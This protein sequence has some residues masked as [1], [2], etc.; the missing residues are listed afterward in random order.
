L[1]SKI[2][3]SGFVGFGLTLVISSLRRLRFVHAGSAGFGFFDMGTNVVG[4]DIVGTFLTRFGRRKGTG[5]ARAAQGFAGQDF[6]RSS[7]F[8]DDLRGGRV[9]IAAA[10]IMA[11]AMIVI[12][13]IF[14]NITDIEKGIAVE[15][16]VHESGLHAGK[17]AGDFAFVDA[18]DEGEFFFALDVDFD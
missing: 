7:D 8:A 12:V 17:D 10:G 14:K 6:D 4:F 9:A 15:T 2:R 5:R 16:D 13:Q 1:R 11:V 3:R 18:A